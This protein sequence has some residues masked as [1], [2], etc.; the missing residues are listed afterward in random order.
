ME[1]L[2]NQRKLR[3][4]R[5]GGTKEGWAKL[6]GHTYLANVVIMVVEEFIEMARIC[7]Q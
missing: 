5:V 2:F 3:V 4:L 7:K 1:L 6:Y